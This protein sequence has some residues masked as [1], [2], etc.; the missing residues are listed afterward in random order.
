MSESHCKVCGVFLEEMEHNRG[1]PNK[2][3]EITAGED[4]KSLIVGTADKFFVSAPDKDVAGRCAVE[5]L[6]SQDLYPN[7]H[8]VL[9]IFEYD[10]P[11]EYEEQP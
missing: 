3:W 7:G 1:C 8:K 11:E 5:V 4:Y 6:G 2:T 9:K 10:A